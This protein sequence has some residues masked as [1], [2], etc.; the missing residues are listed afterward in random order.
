MH[1]VILIPF[2]PIAVGL[3][4]AEECAADIYEYFS[5]ALCNIDINS[6]L[7]WIEQRTGYNVTHRIFQQIE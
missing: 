5:Q 6:F 7:F 2:I 3:L 1:G 4:F